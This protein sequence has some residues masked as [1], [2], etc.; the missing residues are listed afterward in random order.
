ML[1][2]KGLPCSVFSPLSSTAKF[3]F[4]KYA[5]NRNQHCQELSFCGSKCLLQRSPAQSQ[6]YGQP[7]VNHG[8]P[9]AFQWVVVHWSIINASLHFCQRKSLLPDLRSILHVIKP[10]PRSIKSFEINCVS[11][12]AVSN[13]DC[14]YWCLIIVALVSDQL[15]FKSLVLDQLLFQVN[16][17]TWIRLSRICTMMTSSQTTYNHL[18][19]IPYTQFWQSLFQCHYQGQPM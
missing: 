13:W 11:S 15:L 16:T 2:D 19:K 12:S 18:R 5:I 17:S 8:Q 9:C 3:C 6:Y 10:N 4:G 7:L 1:C 14:H